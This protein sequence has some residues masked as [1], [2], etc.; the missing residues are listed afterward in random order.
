MYS[1]STKNCENAMAPT[2]TAM[3]FAAASVRWRKMRSGSSGAFERSS[4]T[5]NAAR[6]SADPARSPSV[7]GSPQPD[8]TVRVNA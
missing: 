5:M 1:V 2:I 6:S 4:I 3:P 8:V 7:V